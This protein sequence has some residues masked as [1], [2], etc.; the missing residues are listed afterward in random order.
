VRAA[1]GDLSVPHLPGE[2]DGHQL[3]FRAVRRHGVAGI[4]G[5]RG[6]RP[7]GKQRAQSPAS[8]RPGSVGWASRQA[9]GTKR[10]T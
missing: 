9:A 7:T 5:S 3:A 10:A 8:R 2:Q 1:G 4:R 6:V